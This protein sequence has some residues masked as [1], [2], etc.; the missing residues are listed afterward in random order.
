VRSALEW[1][2]V[3]AL[4]ADGVSQR[5]IACQLGMNRRT[6]ARLLGS[7]EPP[8]Y[9]R[10]RVGSQLDPFEPVLR[11]L[12]EEW[13]QIKAPR[14]TEILR[15]DYGY[16]GSLRLVQVR[17]QQLRPSRVRAAQRTGYRPGQV[18][19]LDWGEMATRPRVAGRERRVYALVASLPYSGAQTVFFSLDMTIESFLEGHVRAFEWLGGVPRECV[20]D[21]LRAVVAR[22]DGDEVIWNRRFLHLRGHY[23]FH[24][25]PCTPATP[26]EKGSVEAAV[27]YLKS[28]FWPARRFT[29]L[30]E[31]DGQYA[32]WRDRICNRRTHATGRFPVEERLVEERQ[33][34]RSL[35]PTRFDWSGHRSS[36]VPIDGYL[37]HGRCFYRAPERLVHERVEL[38]FDRDQVWVVHRGVEV[39]RYPRSYEQG[40]WL[41]PPIMRPEPPAAAPPVLL[42]RLE[43]APPELADYAELCA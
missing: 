16:T 26:R 15:F 25:T 37:R 6:V 23:G 5:E 7:D 9:R 21:N 38:G 3:R 31:L 29:E 8:R 4:A 13:P 18:L 10:A 36:R 24:A 12:L 39:A 34:L 17:L 40:V 35:P 30:G 28:G 41:P 14:L 42:P 43:V 1:A 22:R 20:Y 11:R 33:A 27:R 32:D 19:Q 2:Q